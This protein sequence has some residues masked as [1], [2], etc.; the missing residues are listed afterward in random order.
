VQILTKNLL[1]KLLNNIRRKYMGIMDKMK[2]AKDMYG[3]MKKM[4]QEVDKIVIEVSSRDKLIIV[5]VKGNHQ[6][7]SIKIDDQLQNS[8][9]R[10]IEKQIL[11]TCNEALGKVDREVK[12]KM[13]SMMNLPGGL[14]LPF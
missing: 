10:D 13:G 1:K 9:L 6:I 12:S 3:N 11:I 2:Q 8:D 5:A 14:K 4:Q 7:L